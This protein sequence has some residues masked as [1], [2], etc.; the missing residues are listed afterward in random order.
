MEIAS[1]R[2]AVEWSKTVRGG[3]QYDLLTESND[4]TACSSAYG[5]C[6]SSW[7]PIQIPEAA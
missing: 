2:Q 1:I 5:L 7:E 6:E 3:I 4:T